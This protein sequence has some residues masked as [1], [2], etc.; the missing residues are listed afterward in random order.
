MLI[1]QL[2]IRLFD[3]STV[4]VTLGTGQY[5]RE[6][7]RPAI[8][9]ISTPVPEV[10][11]LPRDKLDEIRD[12]MVKHLETIYKLRE[13]LDSDKGVTKRK[14]T[15][16]ANIP[17]S[18]SRREAWPP[19]GPSR[20]IKL[21]ENV[22]LVPP[23]AGPTGRTNDKWVEIGKVGKVK[24]Q[25]TQEGKES[26][27]V[28]LPNRKSQVPEKKKQEEGSKR[29]KKTPKE[30][31]KDKMGATRRVPKTAAISIK[32]SDK[33]FSYAQA[34]KIARGKIDLST[35]GIEN[36]KVARVELLKARLT[37]CYRCWEYGHV[38]NN[39]TSNEDR[40]NDC[41]NCG[42][43]GH[44]MRECGV[45]A[46]CVLCTKRGKNPEH[47]SGSYMCGTAKDFMQKDP[48]KQ[49]RQPDRRTGEGSMEVGI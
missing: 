11:K 14:E 35:M 26:T 12:D 41:C 10:P 13:E 19:L 40:S 16:E 31:I 22:Q 30:I 46:H 5:Q 21:I 15:K 23:K 25:R 24:K 28:N 42:G 2:Q 4:L 38:R 47:K 39:C 27:E 29:E 33:E 1:G 8:K 3:W 34:L 20:G 6:V 37:Q 18:T 36:S 45:K 43:H 48:A 9:G 7:M 44:T 17:S 49:M 32:S